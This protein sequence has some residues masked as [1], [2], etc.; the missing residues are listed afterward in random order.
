MS[1]YENKKNPA[2]QQ[3]DT[4]VKG[5]ANC[6]ERDNFNAYSNLKTQAA[7]IQTRLL[8]AK[9]TWYD[10]AGKIKQYNSELESE[11]KI[12]ARE[13]TDDWKGKFDLLYKALEDSFNNISSLESYCPRAESLSM[14]YLSL[15]EKINDKTKKTIKQAN[16]N[17]R[18]AA[19]YD[20]SD[21]YED[22][23]YYFKWVYWVMFLFVI[24]M[25]FMSGQYRNVKT[26]VLIIVLAA[27]PTLLLKPIVTWVNTHVS[28]VKINTMWFS[29]IIL[30]SLVVSM[31][32]YSGNFAMPNEKIEMAPPPK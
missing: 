12:K 23:L 28:Q 1:T 30:G 17:H 4:C 5:S 31:L 26:Y 29:F 9:K 7:T 32:Y 13:T 2:A 18:L 21:Y 27:F 6:P 22:L 20:N 25:L 15:T 10:S 11:S 24:V 14:K 19:F 3:L 16:I 8:E